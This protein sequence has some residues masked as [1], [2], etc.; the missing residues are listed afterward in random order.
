MLGRERP[1][2]KHVTDIIRSE[3]VLQAGDLE[4]VLAGA[5]PIGELRDEAWIRTDGVELCYDVRV[6]A[7]GPAT[8]P[9]DT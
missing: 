2:G 3:M 4:P 1:V 8:T 7:I 6:S 9:S 5:E